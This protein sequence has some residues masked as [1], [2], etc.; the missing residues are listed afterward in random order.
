MYLIV[1]AHGDLA[2]EVLNSANMVYGQVEN[3]STV[4]FVPGENGTNLKR[5]Y[6]EILKDVNDQVVFLVDLFGGSPYNAA[7]EFA[8]KNDNMD[9]VTGLSLPM[10]IEVL[11]T[12]EMNSEVKAKELIHMINPDGYVKSCK[13][14]L[15]E[16]QE[17]EEEDDL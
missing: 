3:I 8:L 17:E 16:K 4:S 13:M 15:N 11:T 1:A 12:R 5:K 7:F 14:M 10:L 2:K 9:V 6:E